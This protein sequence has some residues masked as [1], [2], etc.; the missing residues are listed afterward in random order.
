M[1]LLCGLFSMEYNVVTMV[2]VVLCL[3]VGLLSCATYYWMPG[4][5][6][7]GVWCFKRWVKIHVEAAHL[8]TKPDAQSTGRIAKPETHLEHIGLQSEKFWILFIHLEIIDYTLCLIYPTIQFWFNKLGILT[9]ELRVVG[10]GA[11]F[12]FQY[13]CLEHQQIGHDDCEG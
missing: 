5:W 9:K 2:V 12:L 11:H 6:W 10:L 7:S 4:V 13:I 1:S 3:N 8:G